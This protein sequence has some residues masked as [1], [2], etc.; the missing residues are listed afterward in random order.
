MFCGVCGVFLVHGVV[1]Y[2]GI[3]V[4]FMYVGDLILIILTHQIQNLLCA[5]LGE[6]KKV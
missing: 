5:V 4:V 2:G 1:A 6:E 3:M